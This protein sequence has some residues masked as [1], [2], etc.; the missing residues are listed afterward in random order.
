MQIEIVAV[1]VEDKGKYQMLDV[2][3]RSD[4]QIKGKKLMSFTFPEVFKAMKAAQQGEVFEVRTQKNDKNFWDW[5]EVSKGG[6]AQTGGNSMATATTASPKSTY[7]TAEE[8][9]NRQILIVRQS[10]VSNAIEYLKLN[11]KKVPSVE[12]VINIASKLEDFV[13]GRK[14]DA[15]A[16]VDFVDDIL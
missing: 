8:R 16:G 13:F 6:S 14:F 12:E 3:Y 5:V 7:E 4:G 15:A 10:S 11:P 1:K 9:A 2:A